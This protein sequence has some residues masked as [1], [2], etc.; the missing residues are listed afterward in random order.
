MRSKDEQ[1]KSLEEKIKQLSNEF[2]R[3]NKENK[4]LIENMG[5][6]R[7]PPRIIKDTA[8]IRELREIIKDLEDEIGDLQISLRSTEV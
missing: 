3:I 4:K 1:I 7:R 8:T 2:A 6:Q 5:Y